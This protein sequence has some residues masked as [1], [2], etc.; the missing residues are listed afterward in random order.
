MR[1]WEYGVAAVPE[2]GDQVEITPVLDEATARAF[3]RDNWPDA[4]MYRRPFPKPWRLIPIL[5][6]LLTLLACTS[7][8]EARTGGTYLGRV[9]V[10]A[11]ASLSSW[12][13][14]QVFVYGHS[15]TMGPD[16]L[17]GPYP[18]SG[19]SYG[20]LIGAHYG[21]VKDYNGRSGTRLLDTVRGVT[22]P[23]FDGSTARLWAVGNGHGSSIVTLENGH[24]DMASSLGPD[25][26]Y[27]DGY[28]LALNLAL[29]AFGAGSKTLAASGTHVGSWTSAAYPDRAP[30]GALE[31][32]KTFGDKISF[33]VTSSAVTIAT[34]ASDAGLAY[35]TMRIEVNGATVGY[36]DGTGRSEAYA[37][38]VTGVTRSWS[39]AGIH[40]TGLT[41]TSTV[42]LRKVSND[43]LPIWVSAVY[44][45]SAIPP[46]V[47]LGMEPQR[48]EDAT[49]QA[50]VANFDADKAQYRAIWQAACADYSFT[51]CVDLDAASVSAPAWDNATMVATN[52]PSC[53]GTDC[54]KAADPYNF[55]PNA[56]GMVNI[57]TKF[58]DAIDAS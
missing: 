35:G 34:V 36:Y 43:A 8:A 29:G 53:P 5:L 2:P 1:R 18:Y 12:T 14:D 42:T 24:N 6:L 31:Y 38:S 9:A 40:L 22:A 46:H 56:A 30:G 16:S 45:Q 27:Q 33:T 21:V 51:R 25:A 26:A 28:G 48:N 20:S 7:P 58:D 41:G 50:A 47:F 4:V 15:F 23:S 55:H 13:P 49:D 37:D 32:T 39:N 10:K 17:T 54:G 52:P 44:Q 3:V 11:H 19:Y 57:A